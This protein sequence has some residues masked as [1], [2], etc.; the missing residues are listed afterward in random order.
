MT[1]KNVR[2]YLIALYAIKIRICRRA[3]RNSHSRKK[4]VYIHIEI[5]ASLEKFYGCFVRQARPTR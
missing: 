5:S 1:N 4:I 2:L 3:R